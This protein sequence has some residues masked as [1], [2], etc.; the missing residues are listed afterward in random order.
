MDDALY[1][2]DTPYPAMKEVEGAERQTGQIDQKIVATGE[3]E[4]QRKL[5]DSSDPGGI[6]ESFDQVYTFAFEDDVAGKGVD[7]METCND[8]QG[9]VSKEDKSL[10]PCGKR[11]SEAAKRR[12]MGYGLTPKSRQKESFVGNSG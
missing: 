3:Q 5:E 12:T 10:G 8:V 11:K 1:N 9:N 6:T 7:T 4:H 2:D